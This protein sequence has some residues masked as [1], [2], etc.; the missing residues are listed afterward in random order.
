MK[1]FL[2]ALRYLR[3]LRGGTVA[4]VI[5]LSLGLAVGLLIFSYAN[6]NLT[7]DRCF[8]DGDRIYQL[9]VH[10]NAPQMTGYSSSLQAPIAPALAEEIPQIEA[11][12]RL[13]GTTPTMWYAGTIRF[14][15]NIFWPI[16]CFS[17]CWASMCSR[18]IRTGRLRR[19][20]R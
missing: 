2:F 10:Y 19:R 18:A 4:R 12:T 1:N 3:K 6:Y 16:R 20:T 15:C 7:S 17:T 9:W 13:W 5:S 8:R 11:A 14:R